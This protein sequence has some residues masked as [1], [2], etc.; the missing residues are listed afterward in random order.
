MDA[1]IAATASRTL[2]SLDIALSKPGRTSHATPSEG[3]G[4]ISA[5]NTRR[6]LRGARLEEPLE[7]QIY[8]LSNDARHEQF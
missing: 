7:A 5:C 2:S 3:S 4:L 1:L 8:L 6:V